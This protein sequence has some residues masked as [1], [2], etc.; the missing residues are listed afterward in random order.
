MKVIQF[1]PTLESGGVEQGVLEI[2]KA[3]VDAGHESHVVSAGG[4]L[5]DQLIHDGTYH[6][7]WELHKKNIFTLRQVKPLARWIEEMK[8]DILHVR[9]RMPAWIVW[10]ALNKI[11]EQKRP[12]LVSTI[13]GLYSVNFYSAVMSKPENIITVS[14]SAHSYL[15]NNYQN[16]ESKNIKLIYRGVD[17]TEYF[18]GYKPPSNWLDKWYTDYPDTKNCKL[19]T[20]A[21]RIS[22][23]KDFEKIIN[24]TKDIHDQSNHRVKVLIAG[25]AKDKHKK[26][27]DRLKK[28]IHTLNLE[29]DIYFLN[30]RK[31]IKNIYAISNIVFNTSNKPESF[32]RSI[33]EPLSIGVP[34][35]GYSRGGV[36]EI[37]EELYPYGSV[38]PNN[39]KSLLNKSLSILDGNNKEIKENTK[40]LKSNMCQSTINFYKEIISC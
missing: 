15:V 4:R 34:S 28:L 17:K 21:G 2:S 13:H 18:Y 9:S 26:Y 19:L 29:S 30:F 11:P 32:G 20:I 37:L 7:H 22:P 16:T 27:L 10:K 38:E 14:N 25:E 3:L 33:L 12:K 24:L 35:I 5:V 36:K 8:A 23:L 39:T 1:V 31:D 40:F 6:H